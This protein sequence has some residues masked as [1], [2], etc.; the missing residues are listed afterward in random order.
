MFFLIS[1][2]RSCNVVDITNVVWTVMNTTAGT[3]SVEFDLMS[4]SCAKTSYMLYLYI[5]DNV[6][7]EEE[8]YKNTFLLHS[9]RRVKILNHVA[10]NNRK[11]SPCG[12]VCF[13]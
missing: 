1:E 13:V 3:L 6:T 10:E 2:V 5:S 7:S 4:Q 9:K 8:C 11:V 12:K